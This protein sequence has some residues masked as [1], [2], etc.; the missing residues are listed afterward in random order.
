MAQ[1]DYQPVFEFLTLCHLKD[2]SWCYLIHNYVQKMNLQSY[3]LIEESIKIWDADLLKDL[4]E[5]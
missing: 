3:V 2:Q 5:Y 4:V 1:M